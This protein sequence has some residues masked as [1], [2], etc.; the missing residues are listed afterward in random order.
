MKFSADQIGDVFDDRVRRL[1]DL[2]TCGAFT[3]LKGRGDHDS[4]LGRNWTRFRTPRLLPA[5]WMCGRLCG[6]LDRQ[7]ERKILGAE[8]RNLLE[9]SRPSRGPRFEIAKLVGHE[10]RPFL[11]VWSRH[12]S[13]TELAVELDQPVAGGRG[14]P[15]KPVALG[16]GVALQQTSFVQQKVC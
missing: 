10:Q 6:R 5:G 12:G 3:P 2:V 11:V 14:R 15:G 16:D 7:P 9:T 8:W 4:R 1:R 13:T